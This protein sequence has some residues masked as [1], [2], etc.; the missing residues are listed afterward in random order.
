MR[1]YPSTADRAGSLLPVVPTGKTSKDL[2]IASELFQLNPDHDQLKLTL[3]VT[4]PSG[5]RG[6]QHR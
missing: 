5:A 6:Q 1:S 4:T 2:A 3:R